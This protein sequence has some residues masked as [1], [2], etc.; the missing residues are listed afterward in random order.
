MGGMNMAL[1]GV[2]ERLPRPARPQGRAL[3]HRVG[4]QGG[5]P[6]SGRRRLGAEVRMVGR[7]GDDLFGPRLLEALRGKG[8]DVSGVAVDP[9]HASGVG[10]IL[11]DK[12]RQN[13]VTAIYGANLQC[14]DDQVRAVESALEGAD[15]LLLQMEIPFDVSLA[16]AR[17]A[18]ERGVRVVLDPAPAAEIPMSAYADL[19]IVTPNQT[20]AEFHTGI[21]V[22]DVPSARASAET[23]LERG[24]TAAIVKM[25]EQGVYYTSNSGSGHVPPFEVEVIDTVSAGD[26]FGGALAVALA[27]GKTLEDAV[28]YGAAAGALAVTRRGVQDSMPQRSEVEALL[29]R[30]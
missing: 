6:G 11:L 20:E 18:T 10:M 24:A 13:H 8:V 22:T 27:E 26:A 29:S 9:D 25:A 30:G 16:A 5:D 23:L 12:H 3:L 17:A 15:A 14:D 7:V 4:R 19:D 2:A 28:R 1:I 21:C